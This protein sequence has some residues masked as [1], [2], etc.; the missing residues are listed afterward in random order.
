MTT[1]NAIEVVAAVIIVLG[2]VRLLL[3][4]RRW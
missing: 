2:A 3:L 4:V 1:H